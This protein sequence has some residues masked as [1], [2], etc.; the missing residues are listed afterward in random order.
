MTH[1]EKIQILWDKQEITEVAYRF[2]R[3]LDRVDAALMKDCYWP[4]AIEAHQD[5]IFPEQFFY[6]G[7]A[8]TFVPIAMEGFKTLKTTQHRV[9]NML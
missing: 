9:S 5:P 6:D 8:H 4:D 2:A 1:E 3:A 7:N